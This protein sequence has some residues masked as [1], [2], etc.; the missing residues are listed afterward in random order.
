[1]IYVGKRILLGV[2]GGIA[3]YKAAELARRLI[4]AG[5]K[6]KVVMTAAAAGF[7]GPL[8]F[9]AL[10]GEKVATAMFGP[11]AEPLEHVALGQEVDAI[12][13]APATADLIGKAAAGIGDDLLSTILLAA[14][15]PVLLC[16]AMNVAMWSNPVVQENLARCRPGP[17]GDGSRRP[18]NWP[19]APWGWAA[20]RSRSLLS[21]RP[22][23]W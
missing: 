23:G 1:M 22:A 12:I 2:T 17:A 7:A 13:V 6:V 19:A 3:A 18:G 16:P 8:T 10:T 5:A 4:C 15:K 20:C 21:R 11:E 9:Q 14:T